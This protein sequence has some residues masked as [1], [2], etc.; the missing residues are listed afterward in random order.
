MTNKIS[1]AGRL[2]ANAELKH[3]PSGE[4]LCSFRVASDVGYGDK[5][6]TNWFTC[7][8]WGKRGESLLAHLAK[9]QQVTVWGTLTLRE[10]ADKDGAK[11]LS[12]DVRVDEI[13]LQGGKREGEAPAP[14]PA[15][16]PAA[17]P[18]GSGFDDMSDDVP[19]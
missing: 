8:I 9:G 11:R 15:R 19:F 10:W 5:K 4:A 1:F 12:P 18:A 7:Q 3:I 2:A 16:K 17:A 14:A 6:S 13:A